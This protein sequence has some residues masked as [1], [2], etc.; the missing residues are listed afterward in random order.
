MLIAHFDRYLQS[1][2][3]GPYLEPSKAHHKMAL[4]C[5]TFLQ[6]SCFRPDITEKEI[7]HYIRIGEYLW[8]E[9]AQAHWLEHVRLGSKANQDSLQRLDNALHYFLARWKNTDATAQSYHG[10]LD[11][12]VFGLDALRE[13]SSENYQLLVSGAMYKS[14]KRF[15]EHMKGEHFTSSW[16]DH[17]CSLFIPDPFSI[18]DFAKR[19]FQQLESQAS[20]FSGLDNRR[21]LEDLH[22]FYGTNLFKCQIQHCPFS[23]KG[24]QLKAECDLHSKDHQKSFKCHIKICNYSKIGFST[25]SELRLHVSRHSTIETTTDRIANLRLSQGPF[26]VP[27]Q[28]RPDELFEDAVASGDMKYVASAVEVDKSI[29]KEY[30]ESKSTFEGK[31]TLFLAVKKNQVQIVEFL[32]DRGADVNSEEWTFKLGL[33]YTPLLLAVDE[34]SIE[35]VRTLLL[36]NVDFEANKEGDYALLLAIENEDISKIELLLEFGADPFLDGKYE[37]RFLEKAVST[38]N[39]EIC[40]FLVHRFACSSEPFNQALVL[41]LVEAQGKNP[42]IFQLILNECNERAI[43]WGE[44]LVR[45]VSV[46]NY[47]CA[48][49]ALEKGA[50]VNH[51][52]NQKTALQMLAARTTKEAA[53]LIKLMLEMGADPSITA[54]RSTSL[55]H[56]AGARNIQRWLGGVT[57]EEL[58][59]ANAHKVIRTSDSQ[60]P[61]ENSQ[62]SKGQRPSKRSNVHQILDQAD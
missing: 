28:R 1:T 60:S 56:Y 39:L 20:L 50:D 21:N 2:E 4:R 18:G 23:V 27:R 37:P 12:S 45:A 8:L 6:F 9:Y 47:Q 34:S 17:T 30:R 54:K 13:I 22:L 52:L 59:Q 35:M 40:Q 33:W 26:P 43:D 19:V 31:S 51:L 11:G 7:A 62:Q 49:I 42:E 29:I 61:A 58:V 48:Q 57:W 15:H 44:C 32:L 38:G 10:T 41:A 16:H 53:L 24:F 3:S 25:A 55:S 14:Q 36:H 5:L 46:R